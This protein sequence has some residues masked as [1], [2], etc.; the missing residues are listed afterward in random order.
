METAK[1][2]ESLSGEKLRKA[3]PLKHSA[4]VITG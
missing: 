4:S 3:P 1:I 2:A